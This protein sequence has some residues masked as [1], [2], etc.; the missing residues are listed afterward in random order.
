MIFSSCIITSSQTH[1]G[2]QARPADYGQQQETIKVAH[3]L[4]NILAKDFRRASPCSKL[5]E[6]CIDGWPSRCSDGLHGSQLRKKRRKGPQ[7]EA[8]IIPDR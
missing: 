7:V 4:C 6:G 5:C 3:R 8:S 1:G 2:N